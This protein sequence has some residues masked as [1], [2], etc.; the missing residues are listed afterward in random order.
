MNLVERE[1]PL[2]AKEMAATDFH[3]EVTGINQKRPKTATK[4][5]K[6]L[7]NEQ[8]EKPLLQG[9]KRLFYTNNATTQHIPQ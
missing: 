8:N 4:D 2:K 7:F 9:W 3:R 5:M 1:V 6:L